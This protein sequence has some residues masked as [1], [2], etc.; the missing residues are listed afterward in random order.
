MVQVLPHVPTFLEQLTP[1]LA[2]IGG[3]IGTG[4]SNRAQNQQEQAII[5]KLNDPNTDPMQFASLVSKLSK[6]KQAVYSPYVKEAAKRQ[7]EKA[8]TAEESKGL[9][10]SLTQLEGLLPYGGARIP[11]TKSFLRNVPGTEAFE[12]SKLIDTL[13]FYTADKVYTHFNKGTISNSKLE[14]IRENLAPRGDLTERENKSRINAMRTIMN[15][16]KD[17]SEAKLDQIVN[18]LQKGVDKDEPKKKSPLGDYWDE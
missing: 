13:G 15:L 6:D 12:K 18:K 8:K 17:I 9:E 1:H 2:G 4:L 11:F 3:S 5:Q 10:E 16:P 14:Q 7:G